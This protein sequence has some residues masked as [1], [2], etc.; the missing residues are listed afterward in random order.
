[1]NEDK[2]RLLVGTRIKQLREDAGLTQEEF[3]NL[4]SIEQPN[5]SNIETGKNF[6]NFMTF[7]SIIKGLKVSPNSILDFLEQYNEINIKSDTDIE[8]LKYIL[9]LPDKTKDIIKELLKQI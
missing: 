1:M 3:C 4:I 9:N 5:L 7:I 6:P 2:I 8:I